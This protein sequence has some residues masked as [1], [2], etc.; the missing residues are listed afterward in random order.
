MYVQ[1]GHGYREAAKKN[2]TVMKSYEWLRTQVFQGIGYDTH[3]RRESDGGCNDA[4]GT[5]QEKPGYA[6][7]SADCVWGG[8][9]S[10][11]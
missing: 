11:K 5:E 4:P 3:M 9:M 1:D 8:T 10:L 6:F 7:C 2:A